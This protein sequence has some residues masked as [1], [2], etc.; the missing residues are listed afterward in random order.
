MSPK[1]KA[2]ELADR[3]YYTISNNGSYTG[4][5]SIP[6][7]WK[8]GKKC[9]LIAVDEVLSFIDNQMQGW[10]DTDWVSYWNNVKEEIN[11]L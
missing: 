6:H 7:K 2:K 3:M 9:A 5:N 4:E 1:E 10:L 8:E 11:K